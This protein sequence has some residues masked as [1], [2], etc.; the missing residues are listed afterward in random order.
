MK[1][2]EIRSLS[3]FDA[4]GTLMATSHNDGWILCVLKKDTST[5]GD[6]KSVVLETARGEH[7]VFKTLDAIKKLINSDLNSHNLL[8]I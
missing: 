7:R 4:I 3:Q 8:V 6:S 2:S 1:L 5:Q